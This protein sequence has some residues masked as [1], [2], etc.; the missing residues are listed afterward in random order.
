VGKSS[1]INMLTA[2]KG[3][4]KT[5][6]TPGKTISI[7]HFLI[8]DSWYIVDL[9]GYG[10]ARRS[11]E[12][13]SQW[14]G[15]LDHYLQKRK[16]L[17]CVCVL[18]DCRIEPQ[19]SDLEFMNHLGNL[20]VAFIVIFTKADKLKPGAVQKNTDAF[21]EKM[22]QTWAELPPMFTSSASTGDGRKEILKFVAEC[23]S[24]FRLG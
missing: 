7:N 8:N 15:N 2:T 20:G 22:L 13:R 10:Y 9:P 14:E 6:S 24:T 4:A 23:N 17:Q 12:L 1:L 19:A 11:K 16:N 21:R 18:V 5:S 3:L